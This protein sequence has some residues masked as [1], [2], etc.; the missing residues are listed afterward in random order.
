[1]DVYTL[2]YTIQPWRLQRQRIYKDLEIFKIQVDDIVLPWV[3]NG[4]P[5]YWWVPMS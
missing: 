2:Q 1:M 4:V 5:M 3:A